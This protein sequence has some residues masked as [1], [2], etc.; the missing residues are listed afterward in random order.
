MAS[1]SISRF[2][3][4][5]VVADMGTTINNRKNKISSSHLDPGVI[6]VGK[7]FQKE[8]FLGFGG[9]DTVGCLL[10]ES[11][12]DGLFSEAGEISN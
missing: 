10:T 1:N 6:F 11:I 9:V 8:R 2:V 4:V 7:N 3:T 12:L 5:V